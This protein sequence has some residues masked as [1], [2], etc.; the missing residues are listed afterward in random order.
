MSIDQITVIRRKCGTIIVDIESS[1]GGYTLYAGQTFD[2]RVDL[3]NLFGDIV[4]EWN[5]PVRPG[6]A[7]VF[8]SN[9]NLGYTEVIR[10]QQ[11][12]ILHGIFGM[13]A[14]SWK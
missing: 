12:F 4:H 7:A 8:L 13:V 10:N 3:I 2:G 6:R 14:I 1:A 5:M 11:I 9:R